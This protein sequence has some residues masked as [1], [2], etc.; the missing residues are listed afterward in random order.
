MAQVRR[1]QLSFVSTFSEA[2]DSDRQ[3]FWSLTPQERWQ[4]QRPGRPAPRV[5]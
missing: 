3:Y 1:T 5:K 4:K 2:D